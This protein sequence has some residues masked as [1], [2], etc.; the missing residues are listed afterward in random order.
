VLCAAGLTALYFHH[1][2]STPKR[3]LEDPA[4]AAGVPPRPEGKPLVPVLTLRQGPLT[5]QELRAEVVAWLRANSRFGPEH[6]VVAATVSDLDRWMDRADGFL[7]Y[8]GSALL[9]SGRAMLLAAHPG[10][11]FAVSLPDDLARELGVPGGLR[12][13]QRL[14]KN[15]DGRLPKPRALLSDLAIDDA[16]CLDGARKVTGSVDCRIVGK[17]EGEYA[18]RLT[19]HYGKGRRDALFFPGAI[20]D[21]GRRVL[22][23]S[24][25]PLAGH[26]VRPQGPVLVFVELGTVQDGRFTVESNAVA[27]LVYVTGAGPPLP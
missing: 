20:A 21:N 27:A 9:T 18:L 14:V 4:P 10:G 16:G 13:V 6:P 25:A 17:S 19:C 8:L 12:L 23:F 22:P 24:L 1:S 5:N 3:S 7:I 2:F 15:S 11:F 26:A